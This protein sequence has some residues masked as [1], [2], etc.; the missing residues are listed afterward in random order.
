MKTGRHKVVDRSVAEKYRRVAESLLVSA[1]TLSE[2]AEEEDHFGNGIA[3][4]AV[5][6]AIAWSD[7][8]C[9]A[10]AGV[11]STDGDHA[12]AADLL[13]DALGTRVDAQA[14]RSLRSVLQK[15][16]MVAYGGT[17]YRL[18]EAAALLAKVE[19]FCAWAEKAYRDRP[20]P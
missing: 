16:D 12:R 8:V 18:S 4:V 20:R 2:L 14:L 9:I 10:Y 17:Y 6:A 15:K 19:A 11:K 7:A 5:H 13:Q 3:V 1:Q